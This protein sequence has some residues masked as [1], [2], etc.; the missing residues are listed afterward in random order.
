MDNKTKQNT[1]MLKDCFTFNKASHDLIGKIEKRLML[2]GEKKNK[3]EIVRA[4][5]KSLMAQEDVELLKYAKSIRKVKTGR[6]PTNN[7]G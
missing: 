5:L 7:E 1:K 4:A 6:R 3:S 2:L